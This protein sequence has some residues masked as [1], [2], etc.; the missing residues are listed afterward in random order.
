MAATPL[1]MIYSYNS[2]KEWVYE[3]YSSTL[4]GAKERVKTAREQKRRRLKI[5]KEQVLYVFDENGHQTNK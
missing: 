2:K 4:K 1:F 3:S 5:V